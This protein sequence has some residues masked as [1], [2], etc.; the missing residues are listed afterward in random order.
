M[1]YGLPSFHKARPCT[2]LKHKSEPDENFKCDRNEKTAYTVYASVI[3]M[4]HQQSPTQHAVSLS[5]KEAPGGGGRPYS[6]IKKWNRWRISGCA[7]TR[8]KR[9]KQNEDYAEERFVFAMH[10]CS[11]QWKKKTLDLTHNGKILNV[12]STLRT[13]R[14]L[15]GTNTY[16]RSK[17]MKV[18]VH[19]AWHPIQRIH[20]QDRLQTHHDLHKNNNLHIC[21]DSVGFDGLQPTQRPSLHPH[22]LAFFVL[23][24][25]KIIK[26]IWV[27]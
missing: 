7:C 9:I 12:S 19:D 18:C 5:L 15:R 25:N 17:C 24:N 1:S 20:F 27:S 14:S 23:N 13:W 21:V 26:I 4:S 2:F 3:Y 16:A 6:Q 22:S 8:K 11:K 10:I